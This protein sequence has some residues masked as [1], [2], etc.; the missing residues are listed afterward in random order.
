[1]KFD[2]K[3]VLSPLKFDIKKYLF[4]LEQYLGINNF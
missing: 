4:V 3:N 2:E 1:M